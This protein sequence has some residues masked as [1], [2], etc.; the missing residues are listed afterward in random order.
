MIGLKRGT[1][2]LIPHQMIWEKEAEKTTILLKSILK[3]VAVDIQHVGSTAVR[4]ISAKPIIDI[5]VGLE[6]INNIKPYMESLQKNEI[7]FRG[8]D[9]RGQLLFVMGDFENDIRT[10]HIHI[11]K[12]DSVDWNNYINFRDYLNASPEYAKQYDDLK[13]KLAVSFYDNRASYTAGKQTLISRLLK[14]A[15]LWRIEENQKMDN[16][17]T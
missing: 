13:K 16:I 1:V 15:Y 7:V 2:K 11:V 5:A 14:K 3:D 6:D 9:V 8:E 17:K 4:T 12:W 10:H